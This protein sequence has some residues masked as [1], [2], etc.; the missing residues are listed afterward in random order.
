MNS[1]NSKDSFNIDDEDESFPPNEN[2]QHFINE[3]SD[4]DDDDENNVNILSSSETK[5][6]NPFSID[7][8]L[9]LDKSAKIRNESE[10]YFI[11]PIPIIPSTH[12]ISAFKK[13]EKF[14]N[15][16]QN[17]TH[18]LNLPCN[19]DGSSNKIEITSPSSQITSSQNGGFLYANWIE[20]QSKSNMSTNHQGNFLFGY[21]GTGLT[22]KSVSSKR[23]RKPGIDRK[24]RQAYSAKQ[25]ERLENE[26]KNDKY[27]SVSK[28]MELSKLLNLTEV[29]I[30]TWFQNRRTKWKKQLTSRLKIAQRQGLYASQ[31]YLSGNGYSSTYHPIFGGIYTPYSGN[32][33]QI[34]GNIPENNNN[35]KTQNIV[36]L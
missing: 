7:N 27:L 20:L 6:K 5:K 15:H 26:F 28:R 1:D 13:R 11:R 12:E 24:P 30:K 32:S 33:L 19:N 22:H 3:L 18:N 23:T 10:K 2:S 36:E 4:D 21:H 31:S 25:L 17:F 34:L 9:G 8:I 14:Y 35:K 16:Y 29:Q